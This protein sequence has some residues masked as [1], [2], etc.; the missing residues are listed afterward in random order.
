MFSIIVNQ[1]RTAIATKLNK[2]ATVQG[3]IWLNIEESK[4]LLN[5]IENPPKP[6]SAY[7]QAQKRYAEIIKKG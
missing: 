4:R 7:L 5:D 3:F 1:I 2:S 6:T